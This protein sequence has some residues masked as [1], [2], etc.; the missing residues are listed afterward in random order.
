M[1]KVYNVIENE[2]ET[3]KRS[4]SEM[5]VSFYNGSNW[6]SSNKIV[7]NNGT[8][9]PPADLPTLKVNYN[10]IDVWLRSIGFS[11]A[12]IVVSFSMAMSLWTC[13]CKSKS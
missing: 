8:T 9:I 4:L 1:Y 13:A 10:F 3:G 12:G 6:T 11:V 5:E 2:I 7:F